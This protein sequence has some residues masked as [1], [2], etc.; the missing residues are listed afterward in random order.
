MTLIR[1]MMERPLDPGYAAAAERREAAGLAPSTGLRSVP[2]VV[3]AVVIG[4]LFSVGAVTLNRDLPDMTLTKKTLV[5]QIDAARASADRRSAQI[6]TLQSEISTAETRHGD[7]L[8]GRLGELE[9]DTGALGVTGPG[10]V[11]TMDNAPDMGSGN[12]DADPRTDSATS[13]GTVLARDVQLVTN[14]LW[15]AGAEAVMVNGQRLSSRSAIRFA[16]DAILV[17]FRPLTRPYAISA[18]G[19]P[20]SLATNFA[21]STAGSYLDALRSNFGIKVSTVS[22]STITMP[23]ATTLTTSAAQPLRPPTGASTTTPSS[24]RSSTTKEP[25]P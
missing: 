12:A 17:N 6:G 23:G 7:D 3:T 2:L 9:A 1:E 11:I 8:S 22:R 10:V 14:G 5:S 18:I 24:G 16:G 4:A 20:N 19:D 15:Q 21:D 13:G 25:T